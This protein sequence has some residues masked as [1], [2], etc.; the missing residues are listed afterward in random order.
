M[1][2]AIDDFGGG[3]ILP[4][5][6][7]VEPLALSVE[8]LRFFVDRLLALPQVGLDG[9]LIGGEPLE[10]FAPTDKPGLL[11]FDVLQVRQ[12]LFAFRLCAIALGV[13]GRLMRL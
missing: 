6:L 5:G 10:F 1:V 13:E 11:G 12:H 8:A 7:L 3:L 4:N 2:F 9:G